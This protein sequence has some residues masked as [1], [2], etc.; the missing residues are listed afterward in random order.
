MYQAKQDHYHAEG[1][2]IKCDGFIRVNVPL[3]SMINPTNLI[4]GKYNFPENKTLTN[5]QIVGIQLHYGNDDITLKAY[6]QIPGGGKMWFAN[7]TTFTGLNAFITLFDE[8]GIEIM[9]DFPAE[10]LHNMS[11]TGKK[12]AKV[13]PVNCKLQFVKCYILIPEL[14]T[15]TPGI[16]PTYTITFFYKN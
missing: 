8:K 13:I 3:I 10:Q 12:Y 15:S 4:Q 9:K 14:Y 11:T 2:N 6:Q 7:P 16:V 5:K 1:N